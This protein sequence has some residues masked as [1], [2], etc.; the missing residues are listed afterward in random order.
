MDL[1]VS[2]R[3]IWK[4]NKLRFDDKLGKWVSALNCGKDVSTLAK[5]EFHQWSP[6]KTYISV[7]KSNSNMRAIYSMRFYGQEVA[8]LIVKNKEVTLQIKGHAK[9]NE[10]WFGV[11]IKDGRYPWLGEE[12]KRFRA[13][14]KRVDQSNKGFP[15]VKSPEH[16]VETKFIAEMCKGIGKFNVSGLQIKPV[17]IAEKFPLQVPVPISAN[18]G[19]PKVG[20]GYIDI[21]ARRKA[22]DNTTRLSVWELK[23]PG[24]YKYAASQAYIYAYTLLQILRQSDSKAE[25]YKLFGFESKIPLSLTVEAVVAI[26]RD[27]Q[28][29]FTKEKES[30]IKNVPF[31]VGRDHIKLFVAYYQENADS[32]KLEENP[33][34]EK[35]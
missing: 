16:R 35:L 9:K 26:T 4:E 25:W 27:Q 3:D 34:T 33:F 5:K 31:N 32:I 21:L 28:V 23:R 10:D 11:M 8:N 30:L 13:I 15:K 6:L 12:A 20:N 1:S 22:E 14:F 19:K 17:M 29:K 2:I 18:T 24:E 7:S